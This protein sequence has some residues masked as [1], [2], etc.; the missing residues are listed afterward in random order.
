MAAAAVVEEPQLDSEEED[1]DYVPVDDDEE[2]HLDDAFEALVGGDDADDPGDQ[3]P[4]PERLPAV[5]RVA[6]WL[7]CM[8][9]RH[10]AVLTNR[11]LFPWQIVHRLPKIK[12]RTAARAR[13]N[14]R[15][16]LRLQVPSAR[17]AVAGSA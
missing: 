6:G 16:T 8:C 17:A 3:I 12:A 10:T 11:F 9:M 13:A 15:P 1:G 7:L 5:R 4:A 14:A 2:A